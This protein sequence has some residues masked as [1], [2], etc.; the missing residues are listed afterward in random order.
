MGGRKTALSACATS[1]IVIERLPSTVIQNLLYEIK[2]NIIHLSNDYGFFRKSLGA[3]GAVIQEK[4][5]VARQGSA[6]ENKKKLHRQ[7][8]LCVA[9]ERGPEAR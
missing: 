4:E 3:N 9:R 8:Y 7:H 2:N 6:R 1:D 5:A